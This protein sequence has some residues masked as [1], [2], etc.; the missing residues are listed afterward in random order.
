MTPKIILVKKDQTEKIVV[1]LK[2]IGLDIF[3]KKEV[4][5]KLHMG[6]LGNKWYVRPR[7]VK[8]VVDEL[9]KMKAEPFLF[10]TAVIYRGSRDS[11]EKYM[12]TAIKNGF[13]KVGCPIV[14]GDEGYQVKM[15]GG[16]IKF[17][18]E[19]ANEIY[20]S[21]NIFAISHCKGHMI[22]GFGGAIKNFGMGGVSKSCKGN[23]HSASVSRQILSLGT[24]EMTFDKI[25]ALGAKACL[26]KKKVLYMNVLMNITK[27]CD[28][29]INSLPIIC[30]DIGYLFSDDPVAIDAA[31]IDLIEET[32][33]KLKVLRK[34]PREQ[35]EFAEKIGLGYM[36]YKIKT[37]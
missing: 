5:V 30:D 21:K 35:V 1:A 26:S 36:D 19:V 20:D 24:T 18:Y 25:L 32:S 14:I 37:I 27:E 10:D 13:G 7:I 12:D 17:S 29:C 23:M 3:K 9:K 22:T 6:E 28:C 31:S 15:N 8:I 16:G 34:R 2:K 11:K 33:S 4:L